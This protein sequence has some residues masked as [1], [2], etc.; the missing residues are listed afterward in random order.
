MAKKRLKQHKHKRAHGKAAA[1]S[2]ANL[3]AL[4]PSPYVAGLLLLGVCVFTALMLALEHIGGLHLPGCGE[5]SACAE[6]AASVW[7]KIPYVNWPVSFLGLAYFLGLFVAWATAR[8]VPQEIRYLVR[9]GAL[10]SLGFLIIMIVEGH[11]C[12][13][14][15]ATHVANFAFWILTERVAG[16]TTGTARA[17][18]TIA[19]VFALSSILLGSTE[20]HERRAVETAAEEDLEQSTAAIISATSQRAATAPDIAEPVATVTE[21]AGARLETGPSR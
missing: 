4:S 9:C 3:H 10:I 11:V 15:L 18:A 1:S 19:V 13:Y 5:G 2:G 17:F 8:R 16:A 7:G 21:P 20:W 6:A 14:C 12:S